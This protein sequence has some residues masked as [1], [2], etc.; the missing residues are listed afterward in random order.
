MTPLPS[1]LHQL[2]VLMR[3]DGRAGLRRAVVPERW[4][5]QQA[6]GLLVAA[7]GGHPQRRP[8]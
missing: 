8:A 4:V 2:A 6:H 3:I 5:E 7:A 1:H